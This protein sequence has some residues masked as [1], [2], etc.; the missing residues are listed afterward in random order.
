[1][2]ACMKGRSGGGQG[3]A[4]REPRKLTRG[5]HKGGQCGVQNWGASTGPRLAGPKA[6]DGAGPRVV[7][8]KLEGCQGAQP[9]S[10]AAGPLRC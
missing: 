9:V 1:M 2:R 3:A 4:V 6:G 7:G 8:A 5:V 10:M